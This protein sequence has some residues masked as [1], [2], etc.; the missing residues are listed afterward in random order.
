MNII[1]DK[2]RIWNYFIEN[3]CH[4][5]FSTLTNLQKDA[6]L[7]FWYDA[8]MNSGGHSGYFDCYS[9]TDTEELACA[10]KRIAGEDFADNFL[11]ALK[12]GDD[13]DYEKSDDSFY[14]FTPSLTDRL[15]EF[16]I[17]HKNEIII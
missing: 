3:I 7:C 13:D 9:D 12:Y 15:I 16:I 10:L 1:S 6:V 14:S 4:K 8:E 11:N 17:K 2:D 5:D